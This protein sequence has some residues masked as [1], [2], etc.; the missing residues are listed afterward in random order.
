MTQL[1]KVT[2]FPIFSGNKA[3]KC[4]LSMRGSL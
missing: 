4:D 1:I 3:L 2:L